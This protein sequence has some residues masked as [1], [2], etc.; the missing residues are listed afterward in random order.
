MKK[1]TPLKPDHFDN[2][3]ENFDTTA[4]RPDI[5]IIDHENK[6]VWLVEVAVCFDAHIENCY[7]NK[8]NK[9]FPLSMEI[10]QMGFN[11][12]VIVLIVG[13]L[14]H[15]HKNFSK[16]LLQLNIRKYE[17]RGLCKYLSNSAIFS[18]HHIWKRRCKLHPL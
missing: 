7:Q 10:N 13:S 11:T 16:G 17:I 14:G 9:Y 1:D 3:Q 18:S 6:R 12:R 15:I 8:F 4:N 2:T 5:T